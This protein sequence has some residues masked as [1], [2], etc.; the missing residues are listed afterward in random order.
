MKTNTTISSFNRVGFYIPLVVYALLPLLALLLGR[1]K[2][3]E[4]AISVII[5]AGTW[6][7]LFIVVRSDVFNYWLRFVFLAMMLSAIGLQLGALWALITAALVL[8]LWMYLRRF[9]RADALDLNFPLQG[10]IY[11]VG[12]GGNNFIINHHFKNASQRYAVDILQINWTGFPARGMFPG[13]LAAYHIFAQPV[14]SPCDGVVTTVVDS[15]DDLPPPQRTLEQVAGNHVVIRCSDEDIYVGLAHLQ[16]GSLLV[17]PGD[18]VQ[19]GQPLGKVG[20]S[21]HTMEPHLHIQAKKGG[22]PDVMLDGTGIPIT[23]S[24]HWLIRNSLLFAAKTHPHAQKTR[25]KRSTESLSTN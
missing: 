16:K 20:N 25:N 5:L 10:G 11:Y 9:P 21:G 18:H 7:V 13:S 4:A 22:R 1:Q 8:A 12:H 14:Y 15:I 24:G 17:R 3:P 6:L 19:A 2:D 23:F